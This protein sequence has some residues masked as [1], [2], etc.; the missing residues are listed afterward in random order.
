MPKRSCNF[1]YFFH[2]SRTGVG[3]TRG[4][5]RARKDAC[6]YAGDTKSVFMLMA[7]LRL[8]LLIEL[9]CT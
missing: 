9:L 5:L 3:F 8:G 1:P 2:Y 7:P 6:V 4:L